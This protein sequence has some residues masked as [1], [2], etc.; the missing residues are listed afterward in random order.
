M[1]VQEIN[2]PPHLRITSMPHSYHAEV[3]ST[4][5]LPGGQERRGEGRAAGYMYGE[6]LSAVSPSRFDRLKAL[7]KVRFNADLRRFLGRQTKADFSLD[8]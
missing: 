5:L 7:P 4:I 1:M 3:G 2:L 6:F 8:T